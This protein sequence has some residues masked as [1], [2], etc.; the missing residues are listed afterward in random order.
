L[1]KHADETGKKK[2]NGEKKKLPS[3]CKEAF[4]K[5]DK[6]LKWPTKKEKNRAKKQNGKIRA[7]SERGR[8]EPFGA[9]GSIPQIKNKQQKNKKKVKKRRK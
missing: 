6:N 2:R 9:S 4:R 1:I 8:T 3:A 5:G 7:C